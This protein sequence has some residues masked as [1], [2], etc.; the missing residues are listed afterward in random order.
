M[1]PNDYAF[2]WTPVHVVFLGIF[3]TV[4][5]VVAVHFA[6]AAFRAVRDVRENRY[7]AI[8]WHEDFE[9]LPSELRACR[10][11]LTGRCAQRQCPNAFDCRHCETHPKLIAKLP[12]PVEANQEIAGLFFP[13][14]RYYHRGHAWAKA[15][16]D[17]TVTIGLDEL[18][19]RLIG[20][21]EAALPAPGTKIRVNG[22]AWKFRKDTGDVRILSPVDGEV[23]ATGSDS[24]GW[25]LKVKPDGGKLDTRPLLRGAE[26]KAW[27]TRELERLQ[28]SLSPEPAGATL[29]DGGMLVDDLPKANPTADWDRVY[30]EM[31]LEV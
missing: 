6:L 30:G 27:I 15:E 23:V 22:S 2:H 29:A 16:A 5:I 3:F 7:E 13:A 18:G 28:L 10:H 12:L 14:D 25:M 24:T 4:V 11:E 26:V 31:F 9:D 8:R 1:F 20:D 17:G 21:A 19:K